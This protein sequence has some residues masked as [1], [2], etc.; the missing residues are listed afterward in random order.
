[1]KFTACS[2]TFKAFSGQ[3]VAREK[4]GKVAIVAVMRKLI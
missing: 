3:L 2:P 4:P 1:M